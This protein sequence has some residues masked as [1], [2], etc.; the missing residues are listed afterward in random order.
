LTGFSSGVKNVRE[1]LV[2]QAN[3]VCLNSE[4]ILYGFKHT[5]GDSHIIQ[6]PLNAQNGEME[7]PLSLPYDNDI[8]YLIES[9]RE[10]NVR[11]YG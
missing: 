6:G 4:Q 2:E 3:S 9:C 5:F 11:W 7:K 1:I 8:S 10:D